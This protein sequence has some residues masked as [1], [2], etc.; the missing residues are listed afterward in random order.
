[1]SEQWEHEALDRSILR[2]YERMTSGADYHHL[3]RPDE[4]AMHNEEDGAEDEAGERDKLREEIFAAVCDF[5]FSEGPHPRFVME[6][7][8]SVMSRFDLETFHQMRG[9][10]PW[11]DTKSVQGVLAKHAAGAAKTTGELL[12]QVAVSVKLMEEDNK[13]FVYRSFKGLCGF[14]VSEGYEW[15]KAV[16]VQFAIVKALRPVLI[17]SMSL[18]DIAALCGDA[19]KATVSARVKRLFSKRLEDEGMLGTF[20]HF[21]KSPEAVERY[22]AAQMGNHN[23]NKNHNKKNA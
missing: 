1:M 19:G 22:R 16:A 17:G 14:W 13:R 18:D 8:K 20:A 4:L 7:M 9:W 6:R 2:N 11:W 21:Q 10:C 12:T 3:K 23:R 15:K 5:T